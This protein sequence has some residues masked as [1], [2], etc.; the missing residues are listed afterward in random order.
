MFFAIQPNLKIAAKDVQEFFAFVRIRFAAAAA[1]FDA[2][3]MRLHGGLAPREKLHAHTWSGL[4]NFSLAGPDEPR[5]FRRGFE[6]R[7]NICAVKT[8]DAAERGNGG[9]HLATLESA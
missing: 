7:K 9:T 6:E 4:E 5:I 2:K 3:K 8:R 1:W